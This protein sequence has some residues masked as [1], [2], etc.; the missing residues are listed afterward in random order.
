MKNTQ[1]SFI[2]ILFLILCNYSFGQNLT[3]AKAY[4]TKA[5]EAFENNNYQQTI[6]YLNSAKTEFG[7]TN[8]DIL[9]LEIQSRFNLDKK[10]TII[11][12]LSK[13]FIEKANKNDKERISKVSI[14]A[15]EHREALDAAIKKEEDAYQYA[16]NNSNV[17]TIRSFLKQ[18]PA[19]PKNGTLND[20]LIQKEEETYKEAIT[21][22]QVGKYE[23]YQQKFP[24]GKY[25]EEVVQKL[26]VAKEKAAYDLILSNKDA[27]TAQRYL[28]QYPDGKYKNEAKDILEEILFREGNE[29]F[30]N[31][32]LTNAKYKFDT[33]KETLPEGK[34][35][36]EV[37]KKLAQ[38][39][40]KMNK[41]ATV[42]N[43]T[44]AN[45][46][47]LTA[48]TNEA[49]GFEFGRVSLKGLSTY[50]NLAGNADVFSLKMGEAVAEIESLEDAPDDYKNPFLTASFGFTFK[51]AYPVWFYV[52]GGVRYQEFFAEDADDEV[53][54]F[55]VK[56]E[57]NFSFFPEAGLK[58]K[59]GKAI[60]LKA[61]TQYMDEEF[62]Y[63]FGIGI[64]T[65]NWK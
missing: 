47:M 17:E 21:S 62:S 13:E 18:Y 58:L 54:L 51:I 34:N 37:D 27:S 39:E 22:N 57:K 24:N 9:Y 46:F 48:T 28:S 4:Y 65:R 23:N 45:Y 11:E 14:I 41:Q 64:Q 12:T 1:K 31:D 15:V 63:Q 53:V 38:I 20:L 6:D 55:E 40:K 3:L 30:E 44:T 60:V 26:A 19:N 7:T 29:Y 50:F 10:D 42:D 49:F 52:G 2:V 35:R 33:Y 5:R 16:L 36:L 61:G 43:R 32:D 8:P 59:I 56:E 25:K